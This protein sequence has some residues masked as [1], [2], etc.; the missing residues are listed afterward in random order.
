MGSLMDARYTGRGS[1][2]R[3]KFKNATW[4]VCTFEGSRGNGKRGGGG[5]LI[6]VGEAFATPPPASESRKLGIYELELTVRRG[7][8][9][10]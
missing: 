9:A 3:S 8:P 2:D 10:R 7:K 5:E 6:I 1:P 4:A